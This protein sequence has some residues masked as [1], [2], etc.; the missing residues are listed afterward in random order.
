MV[1]LRVEDSP[2]DHGRDGSVSAM[3]K[4]MPDWAARLLSLKSIIKQ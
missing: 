3:G 4:T 2:E 1:K